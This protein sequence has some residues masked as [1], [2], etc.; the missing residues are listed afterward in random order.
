MV[1]EEAG[2]LR[3]DDDC[4]QFSFRGTETTYFL[5]KSTL[6]KG[7]ASICFVRTKYKRSLVVLFIQNTK[8]NL[9][10]HEVDIHIISVS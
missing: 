5:R 6:E 2:C 1:G 9:A 3:V 7:E 8:N 10:N 4:I